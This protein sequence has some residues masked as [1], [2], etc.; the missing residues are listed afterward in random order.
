[1]LI[2][3]ISQA[4]ILVVGFLFMLL[5][6]VSTKKNV[7]GSKPNA[8]GIYLLFFA[9]ICFFFR[10][11]KTIYWTWPTA[12][13]WQTI[14]VFVI[15]EVVGIASII[16]GWYLFIEAATKSRRQKYVRCETPYM[17]GTT[18]GIEKDVCIFGDQVESRYNNML[19]EIMEHSPKILPPDLSKGTF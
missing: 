2:L 8:F 7:K 18:S 9:A 12:F 6:T 17:Q 10:T 11:T 16:V 3:K 15:A 1:M 5:S 13:H 19:G 14:A 4:V